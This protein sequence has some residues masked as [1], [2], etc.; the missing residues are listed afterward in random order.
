MSEPESY[1]DAFNQEYW[2]AAREQQLKIQHCLG[3]DHY[4]FYGRPFC[5]H[6]ESDV[7][8]VQARGTGTVYSMTTVRRQLLPEPPVPYIVAVVELDEGPRMLTNIEGEGVRI[9]DRVQVAWRDRDDL[10]PLPVF[11]S[12]AGSNE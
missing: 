9:G 10:P 5:L 8:W 2:R 11:V 12:A 3:C 1:G 7:E 6:C 4:Q